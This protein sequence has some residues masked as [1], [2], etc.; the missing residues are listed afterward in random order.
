MTTFYRMTPTEATGALHGQIQMTASAIC[1][2]WSLLTGVM[3]R[4]D[5]DPHIHSILLEMYLLRDALRLPPVDEDT[6]PLVPPEDI[7]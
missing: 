6:Q 5:L 3:G 4:P 2:Y 1:T 7:S